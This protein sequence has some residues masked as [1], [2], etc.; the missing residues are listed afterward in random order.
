MK[1]IYT[2]KSLGGKPS[3]WSYK[4]YEVIG[5]GAYNT[6][7]YCGSGKIAYFDYEIVGIKQKFRNLKLVK[8]VINM[9][10]EKKK[11]GKVNNWWETFALNGRKLPKDFF[12]NLTW[13]EKDNQYVCPDFLAQQ[14]RIKEILAEWKA[15]RKKNEVA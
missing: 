8:E 1:K 2:A 11:T 14:Q 10:V 13:C 9:L 5:V 15:K 7:F 6:L 4:G 12:E 3:K